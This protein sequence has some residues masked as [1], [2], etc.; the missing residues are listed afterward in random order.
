[1]VYKQ[2]NDIKSLRRVLE[3]SKIVVVK[4]YSNTCYPCQ[5][6][7]PKYKSLSKKYP[8][9]DFFDVEVGSN[10]TKYLEK[11]IEGVP[12]TF[13]ITKNKILTSIVGGDIEELDSKLEHLLQ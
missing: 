5:V 3:K 7:G 6:Y 13:I 4:I 11:S 10:I 8:L 1:M 12:S 9:I 2:I